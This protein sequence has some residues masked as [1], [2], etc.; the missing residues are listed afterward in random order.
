MK[1]V[2][3]FKRTK[4]AKAG[5]LHATQ[6]KA[7]LLDKLANIRWW[8]RLKLGQKY[9]VALFVTIGLFTASTIL[10]FFLLTIV[11]TKMDTVKDSGEKAIMITE[12]AVIFHHKGS[13][14]GN[15]IIDSNPKHLKTFDQ[16]TEDFNTLKKEITP[17]LTAKKTKE[18]FK[19]IDE[20]DQKITS[21]FH[22]VIEPKV[23]LQHVREYRLAKLQADNFISETVEKLNTLSSMLKEDQRKAVSSA[24][25]GLVLTL[26]VL[27]IS[28]IISG[29]LGI[30]SI[31]F[32]GRIITRNLNQIVH[33]SNE[34]AAGNLNAKSVEYDGN[35]EVAELSRAINSMKEKLQKMI[36]EINSVSGH[37]TERSGEL[38]I[39]ANEVRAASQQVASTM[40]EL[41]GG[42]EDQASSSTRLSAM[43]EEYMDKVEEAAK[44]G[45]EIKRASNEVMSLTDSGDKL[46]KESQKQMGLINNIMKTSVDKVNGLDE[47]TKRISKLVKVIKEIAD[48]T[49]LLALNAAIEAARA[50]EQG[51]GFAVV[52]DEVRKL[53]EQVSFSVSDITK[54]VDGIQTESNS[55]AASLQSG[56]IQVEKGTEQIQLTGETFQKIYE[57]VNLMSNN[58]NDISNSLEHVSARSLH[59]NQ[60]IG[61]IAAVSEESAAG[62]EQ[63]SASM[64]QTN[65]SMEEISDNAQ[66]LSELAEQ[67]NSMIAKF[68]L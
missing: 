58:I 17:A 31:L 20:N 4:K 32:I 35:D 40:Q 36:Q 19:Q 57:A 38:N 2:K 23:K 6:N 15:F 45:F 24:E 3:T 51:R 11:N 56:Y 9:G 55:V 64:A 16:L 59:M 7:R 37:V 43:M 18:L 25:S 50:G 66:S 21:L 1:G 49:N 61:S 67:L 34:I 48:Q 13:T 52:A 53:A 54:I 28:I 22:D 27:G 62:I 26:I 68:K 65:H 29:V 12:S 8:K 46:M 42:A 39:A 63:T 33:V 60:S 5:N 30:V 14:I 10:T 44:N 47:Q 41:S